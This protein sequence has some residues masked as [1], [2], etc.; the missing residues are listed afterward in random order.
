[1]GTI[2]TMEAEGKWRHRK[3]GRGAKRKARKRSHLV[4]SLL[5]GDSTL[6]LLLI[7]D[8]TLTLPY[9]AL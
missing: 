8:Y 4:G 3:R 7:G 6:T 5:I 9:C 2:L 1:M